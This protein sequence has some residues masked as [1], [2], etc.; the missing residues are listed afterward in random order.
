MLTDILGIQISTMASESTFS[1]GLRVITDY[2]SNLSV[3]I[4]EALICTSDWTRKSRMPIMDN[5]DDILNDDDVAIG[6]YFY[7]VFYF[8]NVDEMLIINNLFYLF[9]Y[10][11]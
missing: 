9:L 5:V 2:R 6:L 7:M 3:G 1:T 8:D 11:T 4:V 10:R